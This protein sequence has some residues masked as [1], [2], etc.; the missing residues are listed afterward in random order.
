MYQKERN[1]IKNFLKDLDLDEEDF[2]SE[3]DEGILG[4]IGI[5]I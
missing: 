3:K 1:S 4:E 5:T 2:L